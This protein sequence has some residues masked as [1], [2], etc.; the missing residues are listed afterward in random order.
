MFLISPEGRIVGNGYFPDLNNYE[1]ANT[2]LVKITY[3][4]I[5]QIQ[6]SWLLPVHT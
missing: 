6:M 1:E 2:F 5:L 3:V 4:F